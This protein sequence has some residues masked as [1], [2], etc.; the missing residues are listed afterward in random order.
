MDGE[1]VRNSPSGDAAFVFFISPFSY[2]PFFVCSQ[3]NVSCFLLLVFIPYM[4]HCWHEHQSLTVDVSSAVGAP[5]RC[6]VLATWGGT[7]GIGLGHL[8]GRRA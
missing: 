7:A 6:G 5:W 2:F 1:E 4:F 8:P 3:K